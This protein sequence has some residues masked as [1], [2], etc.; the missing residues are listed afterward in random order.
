MA[1]GRHFEKKLLHVNRYN[2]ATLQRITVKF[3][4]MTHFDPLTPS[5]GQK[6][7]FLII[8]PM[9]GHVRGRYTQSDSAGDST[10]T[11]R[12]PIMVYHVGCTCTLAQPG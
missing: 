1:G 8:R 12:M 6:F 3:G 2:S 9:P 7:E 11:V 4:M 5:H 10:G